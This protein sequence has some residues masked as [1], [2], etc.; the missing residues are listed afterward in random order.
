MKIFKKDK[1]ENFGP[2]LTQGILPFLFMRVEKLPCCIADN[3]KGD[4]V[5]YISSHDRQAVLY[6]Q[7]FMEVMNFINKSEYISTIQRIK[8]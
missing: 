1:N 2:P 8:Q 3:I 6:F 4:L 5:W 7:A